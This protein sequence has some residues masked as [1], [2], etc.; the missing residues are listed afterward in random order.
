MNPN[1]NRSTNQA[2][3]R[4]YDQAPDAGH[5]L[6]EL[7]RTKKGE[8]AERLQIA[9]K[10]YSGRKYVVLRIWWQNREGVWLPGKKGITVRAKEIA[11]VQRVLADAARLLG[12]RDS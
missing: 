11:D 5:V 7:D 3:R 1:T 4:V 10:E 6:L 8:G 2:N 9:V 12:G